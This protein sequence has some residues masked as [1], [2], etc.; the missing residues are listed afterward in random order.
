[1]KKKLSILRKRFILWR[2]VVFGKAKNVDTVEFLKTSSL[3]FFKKNIEKLCNNLS[4]EFYS[5]ILSCEYSDKFEAFIPCLKDFSKNAPFWTFFYKNASIEQ[6]IQTAPFSNTLAVELFERLNDL[7]LKDYIERYTERITTSDIVRT[8]KEGYRFSVFAMLYKLS[9]DDD[10]KLNIFWLEYLEDAL[11]KS[12]FDLA[13]DFFVKNFPLGNDGICHLFKIG[14]IE[15]IK[16]I[17]KTRNVPPSFLLVLLARKEH[18]IQKEAICYFTKN[19]VCIE[20]QLSFF[21]KL[22]EIGNKDHL[23]LFMNQGLYSDTQNLILETKDEALIKMFIENSDCYTL[24][25]EILDKI[26]ALGNKELADL[27]FQKHGF[28]YSM[29][30]KLINSGDFKKIRDYLEHFCF[31]PLNELLIAQKGYFDILLENATTYGLS[32]ITETFLMKEGNQDLIDEYVKILSKKEIGIRYFA[33][34]HFVKN[35]RIETVEPFLGKN[36]LSSHLVQKAI[37]L[38]G[39]DRLIERVKS[40]L[41]FVVSEVIPELS[42]TELTNLFGKIKFN[43]SN[44]IELI[45]QNN[46]AIYLYI[47]KLRLH[48]DTELYLASN[49]DEKLLMYYIERHPLSEKAILKLIEDKRMDFINIYIEKYDI[50]NECTKKLCETY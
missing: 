47:D 31:F 50:S 46:K 19:T 25:D 49:F 4:D 42:L 9:Q 32:E 30:R 1:M 24:S 43:H 20:D 37:L 27:V 12:D 10:A 17:L 35:G 21:K 23:K 34:F 6:I 33:F 3:S 40:F 11:F 13:K 16:D 39:D 2:K 38:R 14:T 15:E 29:E 45:K 48:D 22:L 18:D 8:I 36:N 44:E 41:P 5:T 7:Q 28:S 26:Y